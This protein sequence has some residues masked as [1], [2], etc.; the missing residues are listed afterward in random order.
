MLV[1]IGMWIAGYMTGAD[2]GVV[3]IR[4][5][6][7]ESIDK[8]NEAVLELRESGIFRRRYFWKSIQF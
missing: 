8:I 4:A 7:P 1:L 2:R 5:E 3:Y 6:Y